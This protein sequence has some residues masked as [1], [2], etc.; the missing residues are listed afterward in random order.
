MDLYKIRTLGLQQSDIEE[1]DRVYIEATLNPEDGTFRVI[2]E[3]KF[4]ERTPIN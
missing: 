1:E 2:L 4:L 3:D